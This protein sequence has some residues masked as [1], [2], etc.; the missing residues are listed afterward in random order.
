MC[1]AGE[2]AVPLT[3]LFH[4][5]DDWLDGKS[6]LKNRYTLWRASAAGGRALSIAVATWERLLAD[7]GVLFVRGL[8]RTRTVP[9]VC[10]C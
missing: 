5:S 9:E 6:G 3:G 2:D 10:G 7:R 1:S 4:P 8:V